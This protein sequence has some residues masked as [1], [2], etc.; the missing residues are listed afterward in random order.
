M[1][2]D[3]EQHVS[4]LIWQDQN[5]IKKNVTMTFYNEKQ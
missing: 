5:I 2:M 3:L 1:W 4:E